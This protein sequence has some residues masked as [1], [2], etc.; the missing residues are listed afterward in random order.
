MLSLLCSDSHSGISSMGWIGGLWVAEQLGPSS[1]RPSISDR[2]TL[3]FLKLYTLPIRRCS[4]CTRPLDDAA[5]EARSA[6]FAHV[7]AGA[8][9]GRKSVETGG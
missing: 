7:L 3:S 4:K 1:L 8:T 5:V 9:I 6:S 2:S